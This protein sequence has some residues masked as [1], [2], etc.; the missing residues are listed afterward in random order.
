MIE[1]SKLYSNKLLNND[2]WGQKRATQ[3]LRRRQ[4]VSCLKKTFPKIKFDSGVDLACG[5][6]YLSKDLS[7]FS[8]KLLLCDYSEL[9]INKTKINTND[10]FKYKINTL[11]NIAIDSTFDIIYAIEVLYYLDSTELN[12]FFNNVLKIMDSNSYLVISLD[13]NLKSSF[14]DRFIIINENKRYRSI[15]KILDYFYYLD[16]F[17]N[18]YK[19]KKIENIFFTLALK[20]L[21]FP[22]ELI[23]RLFYK[24][25][26][27]A[28]I[29]KVLGRLFNLTHSRRLFV[30][31][32]KEN[33]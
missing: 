3:I 28:R 5:A 12:L 16:R 8:D 11:P 27:I 29:L 20:L 15:L 30:L 1:R 24:S 6:G 10:I 13:Y 33:D 23:C 18:I 2:P 22:I 9:I 32:K 17:I 14:L 31:Q 7:I 26:L 21:F 25:M 4:I 19:K